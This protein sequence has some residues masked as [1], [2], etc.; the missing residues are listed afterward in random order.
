MA[1]GRPVVVGTSRKGFIGRIT[2]ETDPAGR[3][4][5]TAATVAWCVAR[6][7][8]VVRVHDVGPMAQVARMIRAIQTGGAEAPGG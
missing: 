5:G 1:V 4:F 2:G 6:G 3:A 7:A 8:A